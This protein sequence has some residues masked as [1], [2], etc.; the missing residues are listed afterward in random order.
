MNRS[1]RKKE[2][3]LGRLCRNHGF[4]L[5]ESVMTIVIFSFIAGGI[6]STM[7][8]GDNSWDLNSLQVEIQQ[9][10]RKA[11]NGMQYDLM[12]SGSSAITDLQSDS[13]TFYKSSGASGGKISWNS[14]TTQFLLSGNQLQSIEGSTTK[15][16]AQSISSLAFSQPTSNI[17]EISLTAQK[18][19]IK[20]QKTISDNL[21]FK[22]YLRN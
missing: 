16:I 15:V 10:L 4:T 9:E 22:V 2:G 6:Y 17:I 21:D 5:V 13:I 11:M 18:C 7:V 1:S 8:A 19:C 12:Q 20:G 3:M 14:D